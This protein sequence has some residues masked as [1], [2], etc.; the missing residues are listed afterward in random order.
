[1]RK[2]INHKFFYIPFFVF[3]SALL[4]NFVIMKTSDTFQGAFFGFIVG[5]FTFFFS[6]FMELRARRYNALIYLEQELNA[7]INDLSDNKFQIDKILESNELTLLFPCDL[8]LTELRI[9]QLG[10]VT[11]KNDIFNLFID[12]KK[13]NHSIRMAIEIY[14]RNI[15]SFKDFDSQKFSRTNDIKAV[16]KSY[17]GYFKAQLQEI[18]SFGDKINECI[19]DCLVKVRFF[20]KI[21]KTLLAS[22]VGQPYF[23][24][25]EFQKWLIEDKK[26]LEAEMAETMQ[27][28]DEERKRVQKSSSL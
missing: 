8:N 27:R 21:D 5:I 9:K 18:N 7:S 2:F 19:K 12:F 23:D 13:Y 20:A 22:N 28:D 10:R 17:H 16:L 3:I 14:E 1:M 15:S 11:L 6:K 26:R 4:Y 24:K 25:N